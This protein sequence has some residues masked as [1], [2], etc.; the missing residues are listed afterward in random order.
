MGPMLEALFRPITIGPLTLKNRIVMPPM[1]TGFAG[2]DW[3]VTQR[4]I[5][6]HIERA[7]GGVGLII[8]ESNSI[9]PSGAGPHAHLG[10]HSDAFIAGLNHLAEILQAYGVKVG[11]QLGHVGR[12]TVYI[13]DRHPPLAP[14][15]IMCAHLRNNPKAVEPVA[16]G[17]HQIQALAVKYGEAA[18]RVKTAGL[19]LVEVHGAHG[20]LINQFMSPFTNKR[21]DQYGGDLSGRMKFP[22]EVLQSIRN[23]VGPEFPVSFRINGADFIEGGLTL[24]DSKQIAKML[25]QNGAS[26][27]HVTGAIIESY[28][29]PEDK[30][31]TIPPMCMD[32]G[33]YVHLAQAI[34]KN[35]NIPVIAVGRINDPVLGNQ[36]IKEG[37]ADLVS[38]GRGMIADPQLPIKAKEGRF[39]EIRRCIAC[40]ICITRMSGGLGVKCS[41]N[42]SVGRERHYKITKAEK[43]KSI[44]IIGGGPAGME[45]ARV[46]ALRGHNVVIYEKENQLG[47]MLNLAVKSPHKEEIKTLIEYL[48]TQIHRLNIKTNRNIRITVEELHKLKH[49][50]F[51]LATGSTPLLPNIPGLNGNN[52]VS[53]NDILNRN[54]EIINQ[55]RSIA[56]VGGGLVGCETAEYMAAESTG[57]VVIK[58]IEMMDR[59]AMD[60]IPVEREFLLQRLTEYNVQVLLNTRV[61]EINNDGLVVTDANGKKGTINC[62][63][64]VVAA[65]AKPNK[66]LHQFINQ[67]ENETYVI[68]DC[69]SPGRI[70]DAIHDASHISRIL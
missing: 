68:G 29:N 27:I 4:L 30:K 6:Y 25:Q 54:S 46:A 26:L 40:N 43:P 67:R 11:L 8:I 13:K 63:L 53:A 12:Q 2:V 65:G 58:I 66:D 28:L 19:D 39:D 5:D 36:I 41:V 59:L 31:Y 48:K 34:K 44:A 37:K 38:I 23:A 15:P 16:L 70:F 17:T 10:I 1:V 45:A 42:A 50:V 3:G 57:S 21:S 49:D 24:D 55:N 52:V 61:E 32:R 56:I 14:S 35:I 69:G 7:K 47:G 62:T 60:A 22:L 20:Y 9:D 64:V 33:C 18:Q 51:I